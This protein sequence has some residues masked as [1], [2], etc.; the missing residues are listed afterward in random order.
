MGNCVY[1]TF[2]QSWK[3]YDTQVLQFYTNYLVITSFAIIFSN[4]TIVLH[5][6]NLPVACSINKQSSK[7][8]NLMKLPRLFCTDFLTF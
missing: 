1:G 5:R 6:D 7:I 3:F 4:S 8:S 2:S